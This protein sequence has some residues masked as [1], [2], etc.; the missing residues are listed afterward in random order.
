MTQHNYFALVCEKKSRS[1]VFIG[2]SKSQ[3]LDS[4]ETLQ[5]PVSHLNGGPSGWDFPVS[6]EH[7]RCI[8]FVYHLID[9]VNILCRN[10]K[11]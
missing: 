5:N 2:D 1:M 9:E 7:Q 8:L 11:V 10:F 3:P 6:N 4:Q